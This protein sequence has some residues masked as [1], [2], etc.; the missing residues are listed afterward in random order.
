MTSLFYMYSISNDKKEEKRTKSSIYK[1]RLS[2]LPTG[3]A[4]CFAEISVLYYYHITL[5][6]QPNIISEGA[7]KRKLNDIMCSSL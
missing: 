5:I 3:L 1:S 2:I 6:N 4:K 7:D